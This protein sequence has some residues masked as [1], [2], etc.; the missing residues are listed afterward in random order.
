MESEDTEALDHS[1]FS[2]KVISD[3]RRIIPGNYTHWYYTTME[4]ATTVN[5]R[6]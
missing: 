6:P 3:S 4:R 2:D 1:E 5:S